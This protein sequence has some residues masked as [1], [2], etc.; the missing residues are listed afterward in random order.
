MTAAIKMS[1][2]S[3]P[4]RL[5]EMAATADA[6]VNTHHVMSPVYGSVFH[7]LRWFVALTTFAE[8]LF[9]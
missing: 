1:A 5:A 4:K 3:H 9:V 2:I 6:R 7:E 8:M